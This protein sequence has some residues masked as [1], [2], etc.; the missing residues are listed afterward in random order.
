MG[1]SSSLKLNEPCFG[2][3]YPESLGQLKPMV[4]FGTIQNTL[5]Q[6]GFIES[7]CIME[8][9]DSGGPL[10]DYMGRVVGLHSR[11]SEPEGPN[12][13]VPVVLYR[14]YWTAL[15]TP[16]NFTE[17]PEKENDVK[18]DPFATQRIQMPTLANDE[19]EWIHARAVEGTTVIISS[20]IKDSQMQ[21]NGTV[22]INEESSKVSTQTRFVISKS[23]MIGE[24]P[25]ILLPTGNSVK[26]QIIS[27][28]SANDLVLLS[29][30]STSEI[31]VRLKSFDTSELTVEDLGKF[32][33][34]YLPKNHIK[35]SVVGSNLFAMPV[36]FISGY[37]GA[38]AVFKEGKVTLSRIRRGSPAEKSGLITGDTILSIDGVVLRKP[39][40]YGA[41][42]IQ[43]APGDQV[44]LKVE[45]KDSAFTKVV[46]L[47]EPPQM[48]HPMNR[49]EGGKSLRREGFQTVFVHDA[50]IRSY[51]CGSPVFDALG[52]FRGINIARFSH[53][54][55]M[56]IPAS[57]IYHLLLGN[58]RG[59]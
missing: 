16:K 30:K 3:S 2:I 49:F 23:S 11:I 38:N 8:T 27:R 25:V 7:G 15:N 22:F 13:E 37:F 56:V 53:T 1:W 33:F 58:T 51:E 18:A 52:K 29:F 54:T 31:D 4:R 35:R 9:G 26:G 40:D 5:N 20:T 47:A 14:N 55:T 39:E 24:Y 41:G 10:F 32:L 34:S 45:R 28:D 57:V 59:L 19:K 12:Y 6:W 17:L 50:R 48:N 43:M 21:I 46:E 42:L 44:T 36:H